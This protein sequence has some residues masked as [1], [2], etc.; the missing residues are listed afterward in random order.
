LSL[1]TLQVFSALSYLHHNNIVHRDLKAD[2]ISTDGEV[3]M[4]D[5]GMGLSSEGEEDAVPGQL[6]PGD[7]LSALERVQK[8]FEEGGEDDDD[9]EYLIDFD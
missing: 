8:E 3:G 4:D 7:G 6:R 9:T 5:V 1:D 2:N